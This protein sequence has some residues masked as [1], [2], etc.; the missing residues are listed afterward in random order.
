[1]IDSERKIEGETLEH[2]RLGFVEACNTVKIP[3]KVLDW[4]AM[5]NY[6]PDRA[7]KAAKGQSAHALGPFDDRA[8]SAWGKNENWLVATEMTREEV[9]NAGDLGAFLATL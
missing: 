9:L 4:R 5:E 8:G 7:V 2:P 3:C 6:F 1:M